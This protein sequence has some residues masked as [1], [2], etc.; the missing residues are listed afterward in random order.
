VRPASARGAPKGGRQ[1]EAARRG[2]VGAREWKEQ[3]DGRADGCRRVTRLARLREREECE[4]EVSVDLLEVWFGIFLLYI[5]SSTSNG[6]NISKAIQRQRM[7]GP[8][9][10]RPISRAMPMPALRA[11]LTA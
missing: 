4:R 7:I 6:S 8:K 11:E 10:C 1:G 9:S 3:G 5:C 2:E